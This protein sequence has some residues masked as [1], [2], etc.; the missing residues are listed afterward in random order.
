MSN[1][2]IPLHVSGR[3]AQ[4]GQRI[5][6]A[7]IR[8]GWSVVDLASKAGINR[9]TLTA[10]ELGKPGTAIG[11]CFTVLWALGLEKSLDAVADPDT[12]V[13]G[14]A[15]EASRRPTRVGKPRKISND[16]DF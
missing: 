9:N 13:H 2:T 15:L 3:A 10:L 7:R 16:Y 1:F 11:V 14:K 4:L 12:D 5:R 8:R 6:I